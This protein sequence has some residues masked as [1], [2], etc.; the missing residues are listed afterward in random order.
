M[1]YML[2][3]LVSRDAFPYHRNN[4]TSSSESG[5]TSNDS[6]GH[7]MGNF[8]A[9]SGRA[10]VRSFTDSLRAVL[11]QS[12]TCMTTQSTE[13]TLVSSALW[14]CPRIYYIERSVMCGIV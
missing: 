1:K 14:S 8:P 13:L 2:Y 6:F 9:A 4:A 10:G 7:L 5:L 3:A 12:V 11:Q